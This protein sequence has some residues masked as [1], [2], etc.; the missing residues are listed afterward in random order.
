MLVTRDGELWVATQ[1][2][3][4]R[5][6]ADTDTFVVYLHDSDSS[7]GLSVNDGRFILEDR[8]GRMWIG[9]RGGFNRFFRETGKFT[10]YFYDTYP[11]DGGDSVV[12]ALAEDREGFIWIGNHTGG[13]S[14]FDP[15][16]NTFQHFRHE[17]NDSFSL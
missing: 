4:N 7:Y 5:Y 12:W 2:G 9:T 14:R 1:A 16:E 11:K 10:R 3:L 17:P 15:N 8:Q 13:L 6:D